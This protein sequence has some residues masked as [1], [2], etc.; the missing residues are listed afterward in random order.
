MSLGNPDSALPILM[1]WTTD[2]GW[3]NCVVGVE[4][5]RDIRC[6]GICRKP[7]TN[8][9]G[10]KATMS[11]SAKQIRSSADHVKGRGSGLPKAE[12]L[13][14]S[15]MIGSIYKFEQR[16]FKG[17]NRSYTTGPHTRSRYATEVTYTKDY[18]P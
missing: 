1:D 13:G 9:M 3:W 5:M 4:G 17:Y 12:C 6:N 15:S 8:Q 16:N 14:V 18:A 10:G 2:M 11:K 7:K